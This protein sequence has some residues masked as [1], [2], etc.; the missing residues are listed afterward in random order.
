MP[1]RKR[2][3]AVVDAADLTVRGDPD[4]LFFI[5]NLVKDI[6]L[7][8]AIL[9][10]ADNSVDSARQL[11]LDELEE[12]AETDTVSKL[13]IGDEEGHRIDLPD[14]AFD[15]LEIVLEVGPTSFKVTDNCGGIPLNTAK[16]YAFRIGRSKEFDGVPGSVGQ[17][18]VGM[19]RA[20]FKIGRRFRVESRSR[21]EFF[22]LDVDVNSWL[23]DQDE[24]DWSFKIESA[25]RDLP[26]PNSRERGTSIEVSILHAT[27]ADDFRDD[28]VLSLL[29]EQLRLRHQE[30][31]ELGLKMVLNGERLRGLRPELMSAMNLAQ[32]ATL[33]QLT[34]PAAR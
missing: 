26:V 8:P 33:S 27:V 23:D 6:E 10:L 15:G 16:E 13:E 21:S 30:A 19:K 5:D 3:T 22:A 34:C 32:F 12:R 9:D 29:R 31:L 18:G 4:K 17:F 11:V 20:L 2:G 7:I 14:G 25:T 28:L 1:N 24:Q